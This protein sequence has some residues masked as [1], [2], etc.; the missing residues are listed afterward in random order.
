M[1]I[2]KSKF[3]KMISESISGEYIEFGESLSRHRR[4]LGGVGVDDISIRNVETGQNMSL[5]NITN[6][7]CKIRTAPQQYRLLLTLTYKVKNKELLCT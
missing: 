7:F 4:S 5:T 6:I 1:L 2:N 3:Q